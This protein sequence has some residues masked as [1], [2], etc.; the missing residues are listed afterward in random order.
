MKNIYVL[1]CTLFCV[2]GNNTNASPFI[3][4][5][6]YDLPG[7]DTGKEWIEIVNASTTP[8]PLT[9]WFMFEG[10]VN[11]RIR[12]VGGSDTI[13]AGGVAIICSDALGFSTNHPDFNGNLFESSFELSNVGET[14]ALRDHDKVAVDTITYSSLTGGNGDGNS[15]HR[16]GSSFVATIPTPGTNSHLSILAFS[17]VASGEATIT[18][19]ELVSDITKVKFSRD[20][21][22]WFITDVISSS[23]NMLHILTLEEPQCFF[24]V[25]RP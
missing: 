12:S 5:I 16:V 13:P 11:H 10:G 15:L 14:I 9:N 25:T 19:S 23:E 1:I 7:N 22:E 2:A 6:M 21:T 3:S 17:R 18:I 24:K 8:L 20:L 4:E